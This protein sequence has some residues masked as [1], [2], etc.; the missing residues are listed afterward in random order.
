MQLNCS[1]KRANPKTINFIWQYCEPEQSICDPR[2][3]DI[4]ETIHV[5]TKEENLTSSIVLKDLPQKRRFFRCKVDNILGTD[6]IFYEIIKMQ[7]NKSILQTCFFEV[8]I[9]M[10]QLQ[11]IVTSK[12]IASK[13]CVL[14]Y[15]A[16]RRTSPKILLAV[17][18]YF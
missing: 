6:H 14:P 7:G 2:N 13:S 15:V 8:C 10:Q 12:Y 11:G 1:V 18:E 17:E 9:A 4:W 16:H 3:D 5:I